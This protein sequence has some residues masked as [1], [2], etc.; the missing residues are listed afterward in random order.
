MVTDEVLML[1]LGLVVV[2][3]CD[4]PYNINTAAYHG[5]VTFNS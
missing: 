1:G 4:G 3:A 5:A 2:G